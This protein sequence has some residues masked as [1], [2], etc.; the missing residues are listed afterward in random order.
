MPTLRLLPLCIILL[1]QNPLKSQVEFDWAYQ[2]GSVSSDNPGS[3]MTDSDGNVFLLSEYSDPVDMD[4]GPGIDLI[5]PHGPASFILTKINK[6]G[7]Y[8]WSRLFT[9][10]GNM[11]INQIALEE[12][13]LYIGGYYLDSLLYATPGTPTVLKSEP[14]SNAFILKLNTEGDVTS[15]AYFPITSEFYFSNIIPLPDGGLLAGGSLYDTTYFDNGEISQGKSDAI[16]IRFSAEYDPLW[17]RTVGSPDYDFVADMYYRGGDTFYFALGYEEDVT[18]NTTGGNLDFSS[19]GEGNILFGTMSLDGVFTTVQ[20][21]GGDGNEEVSGI[22]ADVNGNIILSGQFENTVNFAH[23]LETPV[24]LTSSSGAESDGFVAKYDADGSLLW[25]RT[26]SDESYGGVYSVDFGYQDHLYLTGSFNG[27]ADLDPGI[28]SFPVESIV[29]GDMY[30]LKLDPDGNFEWAY[31]FEGNDFEGIRNLSMGS[32][33]RLYVY[34]YFYDELDA[35]P[36]IPDELLMTSN[37]GADVF[38]TALT[39]E[40][41]VSAI[42]L[43]AV[44]A[45]K[46]YPNPASSSVFIDAGI[47]VFHMYVFDQKGSLVTS[48][49]CDGNTSQ[50]I[51]MSN[52]LPGLYTLKLVNSQNIITDKI[53]KQ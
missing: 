6:E 18:I 49:K 33:G 15:F 48:L 39:E 5:I 44:N 10:G 23:P 50:E 52:W 43:V 13:Q 28:D 36:L 1:L 38:I 24:V 31:Q 3:A 14:G 47:P 27:K 12:D 17:I 25:V 46:I 29:R 9:D 20:G 19:N 35:N 53:I 2:F 21:L 42:N 11:W 22:V 30:I 45:N 8:Q 34:G 26:I 37:G 51:N 41:I 4:P 7:E 16:F 40:G 32:N